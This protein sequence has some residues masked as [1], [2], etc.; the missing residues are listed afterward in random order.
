[1]ARKCKYEQKI[2]SFG[3]KPVALYS[4]DG[5]TWSSRKEELD[6]IR[7][8]HEQEKAAFGGQIKGGPQVKPGE[9]EEGQAETEKSYPAEDQDGGGGVFQAVDDDEPEEEPQ[10]EKAPRMKRQKA[11]VPPKKGKSRPALP[12]KEIKTARKRQ[13]PGQRAAVPKK[14]ASRAGS[15]QKRKRKVA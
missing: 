14:Q 9:G 5:I 15:G 4:L 10:T 2:V 13:I 7:E 1:M 8:R 6:G 11:G 3:G 12:A